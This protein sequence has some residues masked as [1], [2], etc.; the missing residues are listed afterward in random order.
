MRNSYQ[1]GRR[2]Q[3]GLVSVLERFRWLVPYGSLAAAVL[4]GTGFM[5]MMSHRQAVVETEYTDAELAEDLLVQSPGSMNGTPAIGSIPA[6]QFDRNSESSLSGTRQFDSPGSARRFPVIQ[7]SSQSE[8]HA[9]GGVSLF[10]PI[11]EDHSGDLQTQFEE[12]IP[13]TDNDSNDG[14]SRSMIESMADDGFEDVPALAVDDVGE[15]FVD[16]P[17]ITPLQAGPDR[18]S[19]TG[20]GESGSFRAPSRIELP[21]ATTR[22]G[23]PS[24][25]RSTIEPA[26]LAS[27]ELPESTAPVKTAPADT[28]AAPHTSAR[29]DL[30]MQF[31]QQAQRTQSAS[32]FGKSPVANLQVPQPQRSA[33]SDATAVDYPFPL[34]DKLPTTSATDE[35]P[36]EPQSVTAGAADNELLLN[37][38]QPNNGHVFWWDVAMQQPLLHSGPSRTMELHDALLMAV[39]LAP[40]LQVL[41]ADHAIAEQVVRQREANFDWTTFLES[42]WNRD[43]NPVGSTLDGTQGR[44]SQS[45]WSMRGGVR[46]TNRYGG[47]LQLSQQ[48]GYLN[49]NSQF[50]VPNNQGTG[51]ISFDY[52]QPLLRQQGILYNTSPIALADIGREIAHDN[53]MAGIENHLLNVANAYWVLVLNRGRLVQNRKGLQRATTLF[54]SMSG[55]KDVDVR[56][57]Q[58]ARA[59]SSLL[60]NKSMVVEADHETRRSQETLLRLIYGSS[61]TEQAMEVIPTTPVRYQVEVTDPTLH[62]QDGVRNRSEIQAVLQEIRS[63]TLQKQLATNEVLPELNLVLSG[64][65]AG[66]KGNTNIVGAVE[67]QFNSSVPGFAVGVEFEMPYRNRAAKAAADQRR[68][69]VERF[70]KQFETVVADVTLEIRS[71]LLNVSRDTRL[72]DVRKEALQLTGKELEHLETRFKLLIDGNEVSDLYFDNLVQTQQRFLAAEFSVLLARVQLA[73]S[74]M[75]LLRG[76]GMMHSLVAVDATNA[77]QAFELGTDSSSSGDI[78]EPVYQGDVY[79]AQVFESPRGF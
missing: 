19:M 35:K 44:L 23:N 6:S 73:Q 59:E 31:Q 54:K 63:A 15:D 28:E 27:D 48:L 65:S 72:S 76:K 11:D 29:D 3:S 43:N 64:Y 12:L 77:A 51:R 71:Q 50:I 67:N 21:S 38:D 60:N 26:R 74:Q 7:T 10:A 40:E 70:R 42:S 57:S 17:G 24:N 45:T 1:H 18:E 32:G 75:Q 5:W 39:Q 8:A 56:P 61:Y 68:I 62:V 52:S 4:I 16:L 22:F 20:F 69:A 41:R 66:L 58:I 25:A 34:G 13:S 79:E 53:L 2:S 46:R 9:D 30:I 36:D 78:G 14:F 37:L 55:R 47:E 33:V 49:S